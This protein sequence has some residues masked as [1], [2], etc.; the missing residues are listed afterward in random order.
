MKK[1]KKPLAP[2]SLKVI[3]YTQSASSGFFPFL[4]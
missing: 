3:K 2:L 1:K 4:E